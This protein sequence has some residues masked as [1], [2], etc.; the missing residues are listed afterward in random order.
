VALCLTKRAAGL[1][2]SLFSSVWRGASRN[3]WRGRVAR[4]C[5]AQ[6]PIRGL[7]R[8]PYV[9]LAGALGAASS[10]ALALAYGSLS[11]PAAAVMLL[12]Y[13]LSIARSARTT[14]TTREDGRHA[15]VRFVRTTWRAA[16]A[17]R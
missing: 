11:A 13:N 10:L 2:R 7:H 9:G 16:R 4:C 6:F 8:A 15:G 17:R 14:N 3:V 12:F 1:H 5:D